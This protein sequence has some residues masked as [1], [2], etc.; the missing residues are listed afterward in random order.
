[1]KTNKKI[2]NEQIEKEIET[3]LHRFRAELYDKISRRIELHEA[4]AYRAGLIDGLG[5]KKPAFELIDTATQFVAGRSNLETL[6][7]IVERWN[8]SS[9]E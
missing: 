7:R 2:V 8:A 6:C 1:M 4:D 3:S 5:L 9:E